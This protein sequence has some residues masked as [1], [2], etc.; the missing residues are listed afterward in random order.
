MAF[1]DFSSLC[2]KASIPLCSVV[3]PGASGLEPTCYARNIEL[4]NTIIFQVAASVVHIVA[5]ILTVVMILHVKGKSKVTA[6]G[7]KEMTM[8]LYTYMVLTVATLILDSGVVPPGSAPFPWFAAIQAGLASAL[9]VSLFINGFHGYQKYT[10]GTMFSVALLMMGS[11]LMFVITGLVAL[12]TF[13]GWAGLGPTNTVGLF[14]VLYIVNA[15]FLLVYVIMQIILVTSKLHERWP[16]GHISFGV[17]FLI[18]GQI[19][20]YVFS[21]TI[22]NS[23][24]HYIDGLF[25]A[26]VFNFLAIM[27]VYK[28]W[29][30]ITK[31]DLEFSVGTKVSNWEVRELLCEE[32]RRGTI[33]HDN[34]DYSAIYPQPLAR[35]SHH[36]F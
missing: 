18:V 13:K 17:F 24:Q 14:V 29:D 20:L 7:R 34:K 30:S 21:G 1:G 10:D 3:G 27:M 15:A 35:D 2:E 19:V 8:F 5:L 33:Y 26:S 16:L 9:C 11:T 23:A 4:A 31:E 22:C 25:V 12:A 36:D 6:I 28:Y 32:D